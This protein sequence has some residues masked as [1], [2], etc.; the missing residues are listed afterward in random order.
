LAFLITP[1]GTPITFA[2]MSGLAFEPRSFSIVISAL[3]TFILLTAPA[4]YLITLLFGVPAVLLLSRKKWLTFSEIIMI[5]TVIG[6]I[7]G[8]MAGFY[9]SG[10][11][12][13]GTLEYFSLELI[14]IYAPSTISGMVCSIIYWVMYS[15]LLREKLSD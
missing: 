4:A 9:I 15:F 14:S 3:P 8:L 11:D 5:G 2:L 7:A 10:Y 12:I 13:N 1:L 6:T